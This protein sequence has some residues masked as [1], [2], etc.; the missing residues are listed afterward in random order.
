M[1]GKIVNNGL[2]AKNTIMLYSRM[3]FTMFVSLYTTR[4]IL[5]V[6]GENDFGI[7]NLVG[8]I[9]GLM[10]IFSSL[11]ARGTSR[12]ITMALGENDI[13]KLENTF[14]ISLTIH[15]L[16]SVIVLLIGWLIGPIIINSLNIESNRLDAAFFVYQISLLSSV[17]GIVQA[18]FQSVIFAHERMSIYAYVSIL[19]VVLKLF[20]VYLLVIID[21]DK[22][23]LYST[24]YFI[25]GFLTALWYIIYCNKHF[26]ECKKISLSFDKKLYKEIF[27]YVGWNIIGNCAFTLNNQGLTVL[28]NSFGTIVNA[29]RGI[30]SSI[31]NVVYRFVESFQAA[32]RPQIFK[33]CALREYDAMNN[34]II[35]TS[36]FS[37]YLISAISIPLFIEMDY[38]LNIWLIN[39]PQ[40][41]VTFARLTLLQGFIQSVDFPIGTGI[42]AV[43]RMKLPN[44]TS[45]LIYLMILPI[46]YFCINLGFKPESVYIV[47][48]C[49]YPMALLT[50]IYIINKYTNFPVIKFITSVLRSLIFTIVVYL[51]VHSILFFYIQEQSFYRLLF[52]I[53]L[54]VLL[55]VPLI[56]AC[57][58]KMEERLFVKSICKRFYSKI[59]SNEE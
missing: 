45:S 57:G 12:F 22:L 16:L 8:G 32:V 35:R 9:I 1:P 21:I 25:I 30:A 58:L 48:I 14:S 59:H 40:Y 10:N 36:K 46:S 27:V 53:F 13:H 28:L 7:S 49:V 39:V 17:V 26:N 3:L 20:V 6:L 19:D 42:H 56:Y 15:V 37:S 31:S 33:L 18:P 5:S 51:I 43:G 52:T 34:L 24:L 54:S 11:L 2:I 44:I 4:I 50:D 41:T 47:I 29:A 23:K 55:Y 38:V